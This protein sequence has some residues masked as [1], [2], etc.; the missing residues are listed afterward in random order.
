[1]QYLAQISQPEQRPASQVGI[2]SSRVFLSW[3]PALTCFIVAALFAFALVLGGLYVCWKRGASR[4][5]R[6]P[7]IAR[8]IS[9][10]QGPLVQGSVNMSQTGGRS[11]DDN[12][13]KGP[14][15]VDT[16]SWRTWH[17]YRPPSAQSN[18]PAAA[19]DFLEPP[20]PAFSR[21]THEAR[22]AQATW[23]TS[24]E[25]DSS[26]ADRFSATALATYLSPAPTRPRQIPAQ[27]TFEQ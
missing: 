16:S 18:P 6:P 8:A 22:R 19:A 10:T 1:M 14:D 3:S 11:V 21:S 5:R 24:S 27:Q 7:S 12:G 15:A 17:P 26:A 25:P 2:G 9:G 13:G 20:A 23:D 4:T